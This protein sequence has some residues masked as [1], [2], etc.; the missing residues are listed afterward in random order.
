MIDLIK[1]IVWGTLRAYALAFLILIV[2]SLIYRFFFKQPPTCVELYLIVARGFLPDISFC[3]RPHGLCGKGLGTQFFFGFFGE[4][5]HGSFSFKGV[6]MPFNFLYIKKRLRLVHACIACTPPQKMLVKTAKG[7]FR[8][9]CIKAAI[10]AAKK[11]K[12]PCFHSLL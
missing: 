10:I 5:F 11:I 1:K 12:I 7:V 2:I 3:P 8:N 4:A 6:A 9:T